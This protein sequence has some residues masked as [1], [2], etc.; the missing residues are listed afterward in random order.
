MKIM[1]DKIVRLKIAGKIKGKYY[2]GTC[3]A[4]PEPRT[5]FSNNCRHR[6]IYRIDVY[7]LPPSFRKA[8]LEKYRENKVPT[9]GYYC[10]CKCSAEIIN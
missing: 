9:D 2:H 6:V 8:A 3:Y 4:R 10:V 7:K 5:D 1:S